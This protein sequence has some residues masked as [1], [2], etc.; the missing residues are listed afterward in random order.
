MPTKHTTPVRAET[1]HARHPKAH[2]A[3]VAKPDAAKPAAAAAAEPVTA[4][5]TV[6]PSTPPLVNT[7]LEDA[8]DSYNRIE[9]EALALPAEQLTALNVDVVSATSIILGV[10]TRV[11]AY[12]PRMAA[13]PE[14]DVRNVDEL[15]DRAKAAWY[16]A[17][18]NMPAPEPK[19]FQAMLDESTTLRAHL[20][21]WAAPLVHAQKFDQVAIDQIKDGAGNKD[22]ASDVVALVALYRSKWDDIRSMCGVTEADLERGAVL[23]P[24]LFAAV[25]RRENKSLPSLS[26]GSLKVRRFWTL[27]DTAYDQCQ[28]AI[29]YF[30]WRVGDVGAIAP[31]VRRNTGTRPSPATPPAPEPAPAPSPTSPVVTPPAT[32]A[33]SAFNGPQL[34]GASNPFGK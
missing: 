23:G 21:T 31:S 22:T 13:L 28:R 27:A 4:R 30:E 32:T 25:S 9:P 14:F 16:A 12:R 3:H 8:A 18:T 15:V 19:D 6:D 7:D 20:L 34:G 5:K 26:D 29:S 24:A 2:A 11:V 10:A 1:E 17:I 33:A